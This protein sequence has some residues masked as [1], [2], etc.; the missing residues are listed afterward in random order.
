MLLN[1]GWVCAFWW[2]VGEVDTHWCHTKGNAQWLKSQGTLRLG[3]NTST[4]CV[5]T[6]VF[7][8]PLCAAM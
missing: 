2:G 7:L 3:V 6:L 1:C 8:L 4:L 5:G